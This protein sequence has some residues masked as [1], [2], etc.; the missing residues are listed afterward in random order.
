M[1]KTEILSPLPGT[2]YRRPA[3][4]KPSYKE[5]GD[6]VAKGDVVG[7]VEVM[8]TF[9]EVKAEAGGKI[10]KIPRRE[11][12]RGAGRPAA[13]R[14]GQL[15][16][17]A[18]MPI[19]KLLIAN[20]GEIAVRI[21]RAARELG[22]ATVQAHSQADAEFARRAARRRGGRDRPAAGGE[23]LSQ[24]RGHPGGGAK[25]RAPTRSIL[26]TASCRRTPPSPMPSSRPA[27]SSSGRARETIR[28]MGDKVGGT[29]LRG[30]GRRADS[31]RQRR[32]DRRS[33]H[34]AR[35]IVERIGCPGD[36]QGG[37]RR[38]RPGH[39]RRPR[40]RRVRAP[41]AAGERRG[42]GRLRRRR[43]LSGALDRARPPHRGAGA[44]RRPGRRPLLRARMLAAAAPPESLGGGALPGAAAGRARAAL[45]L[46]RGARPLGRLSRRRHARIS[47]RR[48][49]AGN[50]SSSR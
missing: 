50:S 37:G 33:E 42:A 19:Q 12:G 39:P 27:W 6:S 47:L 10:D 3:P 38:R 44:R 43:A 41:V 21:V 8:K 24:R 17:F 35:A 23:I 20:R 11:R 5:A 46:G 48:R 4:D 2:F 29:A 15:R 9:Y 22:I 34:A 30:E 31:A 36:D 32:A 1:A 49:D 45:R 28:L 40:H 7:L 13:R 14:A 26:A 18:G 25:D 16:L